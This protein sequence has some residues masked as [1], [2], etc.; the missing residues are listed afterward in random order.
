MAVYQRGIGFS[1]II[2]PYETIIFLWFSYGFPI[3]GHPPAICFPSHRLA[4]NAEILPHGAAGAVAALHAGSD[5]PG[6]GL[7]SGIP[8]L[9]CR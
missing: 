5:H 4:T 8:S 3:D 1:M 9:S 6:E 2:K 7:G